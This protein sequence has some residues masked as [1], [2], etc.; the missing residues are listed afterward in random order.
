MFLT[1]FMDELSDSLSSLF[2]L[3]SYIAVSYGLFSMC[4]TC[5]LKHNWMAWVPF[6]KTYKLGALADHVCERGDR[7][8]RGKTCY[9]HILLW[10]EVGMTVLFCI[11]LGILV[12]AILSYAFTAG[13]SLNGPMD[14]YLEEE[15]FL[16]AIASSVMSSMAVWLLAFATS[17][18][19]TVFY[20]ITLYRI[21]SAF[22]PE[23]AALFTGLSVLV[24]PVPIFFI[25]LAKKRPT[26]MD[27]EAQAAAS[28]YT[29]GGDPND[30]SDGSPDDNIPYSL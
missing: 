7:G 25:L 13:W 18:V 5:N 6:C 8:N 28:A 16:F 3:F 29:L 26:Y 19:Y 15:E 2:S 11:G 10:L 12:S 22:A 20:F 1:F 14:F 21:Y 30:P 4:S 17:V 23:R 27:A 9:R 24:I